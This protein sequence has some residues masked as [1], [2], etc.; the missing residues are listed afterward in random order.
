MIGDVDSS[1]LVLNAGVPR[2]VGSA[3]NLLQR[4]SQQMQW[5][6]FAPLPL[7]RWGYQYRVD[8]VNDAIDSTHVSDSD[9]G[10]VDKQTLI[11]L[12]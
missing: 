5:Q 7:V 6:M 2:T 4:R 8:H 9:A 12:I 11:A 1:P 3:S 10:S